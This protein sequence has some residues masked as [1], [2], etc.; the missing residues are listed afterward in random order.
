[1]EYKKINENISDCVTSYLNEIDNDKLWKIANTFYIW[2]K[3]IDLR[4]EYEE[5]LNEYN[6]NIENYKNNLKEYIE[7]CKNFKVE[8]QITIGNKTFTLG[9][10]YR[11]KEKNLLKPAPSHSDK[12]DYRTIDEYF[13]FISEEDG[14]INF[15][16]LMSN[17][18]PNIDYYYIYHNGRD[19]ELFN[20]DRELKSN[21]VG[22]KP[23]FIVHNDTNNNHAVFNII[24]NDKVFNFDLRAK[25][26]NDY[27]SCRSIALKLLKYYSDLYNNN[28]TDF[29]EIVEQDFEQLGIWSYRDIDISIPE[30]FFAMLQSVS[31]QNIIIDLNTKV[32]EKINDQNSKNG[33]ISEII[34][35]IEKNKISIIDNNMRLSEIEADIKDKEDEEIIY[36]LNN[37]KKEIIDKLNIKK[38]IDKLN[39]KKEKILNNIK[40]CHDALTKN[41][42]LEKLLDLSLNSEKIAQYIHNLNSIKKK[43]VKNIKQKQEL[44]EAKNTNISYLMDRLEHLLILK[45]IIDQNLIIPEDMF[46][47]T[48]NEN[49]NYNIVDFSKNNY[50]KYIEN[51]LSSKNYIADEDFTKKLNDIYRI[52]G[53]E[54]ILEL[55]EQHGNLKLNKIIEEFLIEK[56]L[57]NLYSKIIEQ[58]K[59]KTNEEDCNNNLRKIEQIITSKE[60]FQNFYNT[61]KNQE[62]T[63]REIINSKNFATILE[64]FKKSESIELN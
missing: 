35:D 47:K 43:Y 63:L 32:L 44:I 10:Y 40:E 4:E 26:Q 57:G 53:K 48:V 12:N 56:E 9:D 18:Y 34:L 27:T 25:L 61:L 46:E 28:K 50:I 36:E 21:L 31:K 29:V 38:K 19:G 15:I 62:K 3:Y 58:N 16:S 1:M 52:Q 49:G 30:H 33:K 37:E 64:S 55:S 54:K 23:K 13:P 6:G 2:D 11:I 45:E 59:I 7:K 20:I 17:L 14:L 41:L 24:I 5:L 51:S 22:N 60:K 39:I 42:I 8:N